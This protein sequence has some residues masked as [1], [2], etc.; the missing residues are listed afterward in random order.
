MG[1][2]LGES[3]AASDDDRKEHVRGTVT[4]VKPTPVV[5]PG[6]YDGC[7]PSLCRPS[8]TKT[9]VAI[10]AA[11][12]L[13]VLV[14]TGV[15]C[16]APVCETSRIFQMAYYFFSHLSWCSIRCSANVCVSVLGM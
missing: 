12:G 7:A 11:F 4:R 10:A 5:A 9:F 8:R 14:L 16:S 15:D 3:A 2:T 1:R 13:A 6:K